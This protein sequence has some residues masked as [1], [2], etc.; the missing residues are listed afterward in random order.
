MGSRSWE[1]ATNPYW[2]EHVEAWYRGH[3]DVE[4]IAAGASFLV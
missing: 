3:Q 1:K 4:D 2:S